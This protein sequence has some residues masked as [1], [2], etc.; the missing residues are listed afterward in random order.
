[1]EGVL[2]KFGSNPTDPNLFVQAG[3]LCLRNKQGPEAVR[4]LHGALRLNPDHREA[5]ALLAECYREL[6]NARS[7]AY[8]RQRAS[9]G[10]ASSSAQGKAP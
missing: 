3:R 2:H 10:D 4:W 5:H 7:A 6:G 8:H 1:M 9:Q